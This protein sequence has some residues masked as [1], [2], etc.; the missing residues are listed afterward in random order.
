MIPLQ[1]DVPMTRIPWANGIVLAIISLVSF[2][3]FAKPELRSRLGGYEPEAR[4]RMARD[5]LADDLF[6]TAAKPAPRRHWPWP[7]LTITRPL[8]HGHVLHWVANVIFLWV[9]GNAVNYKLGQGGYVAFLAFA[10]LLGGTVNTLA[11]EQAFLGLSAV[12]F[13]VTGAYVVFFPKNEVTTAWIFHYRPFVFTLAG[14]W[15][16]LYWVAW[17]VVNLLLFGSW[18]A[19]LIGELTAFAGGFAAAFA[20]GWLGIVKSEP[21]EQSLVDMM[22]G[23]P[24]LPRYAAPAR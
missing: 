11:S 10:A 3:G 6:G 17:N 21:Y 14:Y 13:G 7:V 23:D 22:R 24:L 8:V 19:H 20:L 9:F 18:V 1:V 12:V 2:V 15:V 4:A 16:V 5:A